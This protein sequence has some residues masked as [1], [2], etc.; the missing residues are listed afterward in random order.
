[1]KWIDRKDHI[2]AESMKETIANLNEPQVVPHFSR[3]PEVEAKWVKKMT[4]AA[5][6]I[7]NYYTK[8][9]EHI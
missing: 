8:P 6:R 4:K 5:K 9:E 7:H 1:M 3:D 2:V